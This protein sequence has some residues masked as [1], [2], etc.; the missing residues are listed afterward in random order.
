LHLKEH[1]AVETGGRKPASE[2]DYIQFSVDDFK[3]DYE[4]D[5]IIGEHRHFIRIESLEK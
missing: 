2:Y 5:F 3:G 1:K 4:Y